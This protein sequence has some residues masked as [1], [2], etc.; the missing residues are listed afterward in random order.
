MPCVDSHAVHYPSQSAERALTAVQPLV[1][2]LLSLAPNEKIK[3]AIRASLVEIARWLGNLPASNAYFDAEYGALSFAI[4]SSRLSAAFASGSVFAATNSELRAEVQPQYIA[5]AFLSPLAG[6]LALPNQNFIVKSASGIWD[7]LNVS[8]EEFAAGGSVD[9]QWTSQKRRVPDPTHAAWVAARLLHP[10]WRTVVTHPMVFADLV[11]SLMPD[12]QPSSDES[13]LKQSV[14][15]GALKAIAGYK[16]SRRASDIKAFDS[17]SVVELSKDLSLAAQTP[18][19]PPPAPVSST[20][21][22][23]VGQAT[24]PS[25]T[26]LKSSTEL[27]PLH[28]ALASERQPPPANMQLGLAIDE[29][30]RTDDFTANLPRWLRDLFMGLREDIRARAPV[31]RRMYIDDKSGDFV[32]QKAEVGNWGMPEA[33]V[34]SALAMA[35]LLVDKQPSR[36]IVAKALGAWLTQDGEYTVGKN[37][38]V[39]GES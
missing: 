22:S 33:K 23:M 14:R 19:S 6:A 38:K 1:V 15:R 32:I 26:S 20:N 37:E 18:I 3:A 10:I 29:T 24:S 35:N 27:S 7:P 16:D 39:A 13:T 34:I 31:I 30:A 2:S 12:A 17:V 9:V 21:A 4:Q 36:I 28:R 25:G 5:A 8:I 11:A